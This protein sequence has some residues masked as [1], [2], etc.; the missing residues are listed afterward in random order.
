[1]IGME[2]RAKL[3]KFVEEDGMSRRAAAKRL[4]VSAATGV[5]ILK[6]NEERGSPAPLPKPGRPSR[7]GEVRADLKRLIDARPDAT[8]A[9]IAAKLLDET[10]VAIGRSALGVFIRGTLKYSRKKSIWSPTR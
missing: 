1:M 6:R 4:D 7:L 10:G 3:V 2:L 8:L 9:E 5:R